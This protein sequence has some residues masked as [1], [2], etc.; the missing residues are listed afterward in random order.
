M[1]AWSTLF[2]TTNNA[3]PVVSRRTPAVGLTVGDTGALGAACQHQSVTGTDGGGGVEHRHHHVEITQ[4]PRHVL[5]EALAQRTA[6]AMQARGVDEHHLHTG[7]VQH[8]AHGPAGGVG[9]GRGDGDLGTEDL[10][11]E[12]R[13]P[14]VGTAHHRHEPR[15]EGNVAHHRI[16][17]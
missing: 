7:T 16:T 3:D 17:C 8:A 10:V 13:L 2:T 14:D 6:G 1:A 12:R 15:V 5:V 4:S 11:D 9:A